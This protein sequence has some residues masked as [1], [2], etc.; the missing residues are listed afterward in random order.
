MTKIFEFGDT[1]IHYIIMCRKIYTDGPI[2]TW[3]LSEWDILESDLYIYRNI[4]YIYILYIYYFYSLGILLLTNSTFFLI[5]LIL[6]FNKICV[7]YS[8]F[9]HPCVNY[10]IF[11]REFDIVNT[12][13]EC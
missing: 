6:L 4:V 10:K 3:P 1:D 2:M 9:V 11:K 7:D 12:T 8:D 5:P 13:N